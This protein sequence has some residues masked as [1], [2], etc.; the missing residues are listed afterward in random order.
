M[1]YEIETRDDNLTVENILQGM[2]DKEFVQK[3]FK[4]DL[5]LEGDRKKKKDPMV[6][7]E[8]RQKKV[9]NFRGLMNINF[10]KTTFGLPS[11]SRM[12]LLAQASSTQLLFHQSPTRHSH[13]TVT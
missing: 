11:R 1:F 6:T 7:M 10:I 4:K 13:Y 12:F 5:G 2:L 8:A 3:S 9:T